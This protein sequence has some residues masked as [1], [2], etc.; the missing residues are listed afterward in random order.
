MTFN[1]FC[2]TNL[3]GLYTP[4]LPDDQQS[5]GYIYLRH[6]VEHQ[7]APAPIYEIE[8]WELRPTL[9]E[10]MSTPDIKYLRFLHPLLRT[11]VINNWDVI[12]KL[13]I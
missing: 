8:R 10:L 13:S 7:I 1:D 2:I 11:Y 5:S 4:N 12:K 3:D 6:M 9:K